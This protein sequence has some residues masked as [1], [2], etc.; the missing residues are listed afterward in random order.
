MHNTLRNA[1]VNGSIMASMTDR[2][3]CMVCDSISCP[4][5]AIIPQYDGS[6]YLCYNMLFFTRHAQLYEQE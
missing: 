2:S 4:L 1:L 3:E 6:F 5:F